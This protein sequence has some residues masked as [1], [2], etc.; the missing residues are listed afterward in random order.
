LDEIST[1]QVYKQTLDTEKIKP[2][3]SKKRWIELYDEMDLDE[4]LWQ[5]IYETPS[6]ITSNSRILKV[7]YKI[8]H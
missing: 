2:P 1:K 4:N 5:L 7:Q 8:I 3:T 6:Q